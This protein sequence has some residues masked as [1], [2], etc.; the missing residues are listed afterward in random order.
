MIANTKKL[1]ASPSNDDCLNAAAA[2]YNNSI[3]QILQSNYLSK[4][5]VQDHSSEFAAFLTKHHDMILSLFERS[6]HVKVE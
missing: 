2:S 3:F 4:E 1:K 6:L 5:V